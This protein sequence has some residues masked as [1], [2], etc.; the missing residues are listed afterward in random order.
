MMGTT[1]T[2][3]GILDYRCQAKHG[4]PSTVII[5]QAG[6]PFWPLRSALDAFTA[7]PAAAP[8]RRPA[9][10]QVS[11]GRSTAARRRI[12]RSSPGVAWNSRRRGDAGWAGGARKQR[13]DQRRI[14]R[15][16]R[17]GVRGDLV[18]GRGAGGACRPGTGAGV[19]VSS[20]SWSR[21]GSASWLPVDKDSPRGF[22][23]KPGAASWSGPRGGWDDERNP[24]DDP[25]VL[26]RGKVSDLHRAAAVA[27]RQ[28]HRSSG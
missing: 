9:C 4:P 21:R 18:V 27:D 23:S 8:L 6:W 19:R 24:Q 12:R 15:R 25:P 13:K 20:G 7:C 3:P 28:G 22:G 2:P 14:K 16:R 11:G 1:M 10:H 5:A 26:K 17:T